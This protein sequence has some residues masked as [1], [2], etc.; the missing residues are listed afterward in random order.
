MVSSFSSTFRRHLIGVL[1]MRRNY[2]VIQWLDFQIIGFIIF[3]STHHCYVTPYSGKVLVNTGSG[4]NMSTDGTEPQP[5]LMQKTCIH[6]CLL[7]VIYMFYC[8]YILHSCSKLESSHLINYPFIM[9]QVVCALKWIMVFGQWLVAHAAPSHCVK[10]GL[11][12]QQYLNFNFHKQG[13]WLRESRG[14]ELIM[15]A[16]WSLYRCIG[17]ELWFLQHNCVGD[18]MVCH[19]ASDMFVPL[20][21]HFTVA[22]KFECSHL[23]NYP[24]IMTQVACVLKINHCFWI[25]ACC[26]CGTKP[27]CKTRAH[28]DVIKWKHSPRCWP[29][30]RGIHRSP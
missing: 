11:I 13:S 29:F 1:L 23:I 5:D 7:C 15:Y 20:Y 9:T 4:H 27:L 30:V 8:I 12:Y 22:F 17:G 14:T 18:A 25:M 24:F 3:R 6:V 28:D 19:Y 16:C 10:P 2:F 21:L 26:P